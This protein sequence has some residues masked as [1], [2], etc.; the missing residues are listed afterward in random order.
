[1]IKTTT[2]D[3]CNFLL[4][5]LPNYYQYLVRHPHSLLTHFYGLYRV[6]IPNQQVHFCIMKSVLNTPR[7][8]DCIFDLKGSTYGRQAK[9]GEAVLKDLDIVA[10][11]RKLHLQSNVRASLLDQITC[12]ATFLARLGIMDYSFLLGIYESEQQVS[13]QRHR[14]ARDSIPSGAP[15]SNEQTKAHSNEN[16]HDK[17]Q[18]QQP[19]VE[20]SKSE[21]SSSTT[22]TEEY[23]ERQHD[24]N[25]MGDVAATDDTSISVVDLME[26]CDLSNLA[27]LPCEFLFL[28]PNQHAVLDSLDQEE[29]PRT[30]ARDYGPNPFSGRPDGGIVS[31]NG[32]HV[33]YSGIIDMLQHYNAQKTAETLMRMASG[34]SLQEISCVDPETYANRFVA[35]LSTLMV[36]TDNDE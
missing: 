11:N 27:E 17:Q 25:E 30:N 24:W 12:D 14:N 21:A 28:F 26:W 20:K 4:S 6:R 8:M 10:Q 36:E 1:M 18:A 22:A 33:Y 13:P 32:K 5:I 15:P 35:F 29:N 7:P 19:F 2:Q 23:D 3:E 34:N 9:P 31:V 16:E